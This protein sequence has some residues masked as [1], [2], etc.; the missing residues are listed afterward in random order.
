MNL[1]MQNVSCEVIAYSRTNVWHRL[2]AAS[3]FYSKEIPM[4]EMH[5]VSSSNIA[6]VG[7]E[8]ESQFA[9]VKFLSGS[10]YKYQN[11][12]KSEF[13]NLLAASSVGKYFNQNFKGVYRFTEL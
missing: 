7:Y 12:P 13:D 5:S 4:P 10:T 9:F 2:T 1:Q 11:V 6:S 8:E 3:Q